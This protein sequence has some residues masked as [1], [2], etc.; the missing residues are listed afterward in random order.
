MFIRLGTFMPSVSGRV[1]G[2]PADQDEINTVDVGPLPRLAKQQPCVCAWYDMKFETSITL[3]ILYCTHHVSCRHTVVSAAAEVA[4]K[5]LWPVAT[6]IVHLF[7]PIIGG[8][9]HVYQQRNIM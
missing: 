2:I 1:R 9:V 5:F 7:N 6:G 8:C 4:T 3:V